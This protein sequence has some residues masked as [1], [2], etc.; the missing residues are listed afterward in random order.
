M[1]AIMDLRGQIDRSWIADRTR[2]IH[3]VSYNGTETERKIRERNRF[4]S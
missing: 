1:Y 2:I 4:D 3:E